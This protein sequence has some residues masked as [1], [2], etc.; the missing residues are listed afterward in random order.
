MVV[1]VGGD[2]EEVEQ[3]MPSLPDYE[4]PG[5]NQDSGTYLGGDIQVLVKQVD[6]R[7]ADDSK[8][9]AY[10]ITDVKDMIPEVKEFI[11]DIIVCVI[12]VL[13][14]TAGI[15]IFWINRESHDTCQ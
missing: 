5:N 10:I 8:G 13:I 15:L 7:Y 6:F 3:V 11:V 12:V 1:Y 14:I 2:S 9:S 4:G